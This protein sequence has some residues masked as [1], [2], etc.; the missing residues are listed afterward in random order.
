[1]FRALTQADLSDVMVIEQAV[2]VAPWT[3]E[4]FKACFT[5]GYIGW[6]LEVGKKI[7]GFILISVGAGECHVLNVA[8]AR[9][10]QHQGYGGQLLEHA[11]KEA[12]SLGA[13]VVYLE[14]RVSN[15]HAIKLY[16]KLHFYHIGDRKGYYPGPHGKEDALVFAKSLV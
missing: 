9:H 11:M 14:V 15:A 8:V 12:K 2:H 4:T 3:M 13:D 10:C 16:Q 7:V 5:A 1:M 6:V